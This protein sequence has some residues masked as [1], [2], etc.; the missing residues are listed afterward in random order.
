MNTNCCSFCVLI[1]GFQ[2]YCSI[3]FHCLYWSVYLWSVINFN[4]LKVDFFYVKAFNRLRHS[5]RITVHFVFWMW[6]SKT[7]AALVFTVC[8]VQVILALLGWK[9]FVV[10]VLAR[11][12]SFRIALWVSVGN[13]VG[14]RPWRRRHCC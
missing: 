6:V 1:V 7:T 11:W 3:G 2:N 12:G 10:S 9:G 13:E 5:T 8:I 14:I 4:S